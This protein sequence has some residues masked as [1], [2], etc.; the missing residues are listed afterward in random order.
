MTNLADESSV[1]NV[2]AKLHERLMKELRDTGDP[3]V[4]DDVTFEK[5]PY[6]DDAVKPVR[7]KSRPKPK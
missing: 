1:A 6:T 4:S 7:K 3:R 2:R 5:P